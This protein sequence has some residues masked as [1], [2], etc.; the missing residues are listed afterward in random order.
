MSENILIQTHGQF[1]E[2]NLRISLTSL[3]QPIYTSLTGL[4]DLL[5]FIVGPAHHTVL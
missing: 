1:K 2:P 4:I 5:Y 3:H